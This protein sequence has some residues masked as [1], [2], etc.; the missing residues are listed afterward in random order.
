MSTTAARPAD[1]N[2]MNLSLYKGTIRRCPLCS[3]RSQSAVLESLS[4]GQACR[5]CLG[6]EFVAECRQCNGTG[7]YRQAAVWDGGQS[8]HTVVC[9]PCGGKGVY[10]VRKPADWVD[11]PENTPD[12]PADKQLVTEMPSDRPKVD[13][14]KLPPPPAMSSDGTVLKGG[15]VVK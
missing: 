6:R 3:T 1:P 13:A 4:S 8:A 15:V 9:T 10:P 7:E 5:M 2:A 11:T 14:T 12:R